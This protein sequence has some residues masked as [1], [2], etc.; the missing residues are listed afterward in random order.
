MLRADNDTRWN[1][2]HDMIESALQQEDR[3]KMFTSSVDKLADDK[4]TDL[5]W[6]ELREV[7]KLLSP[8]QQWTQFAQGKD[9]PQGSLSTVLPG[10]DM[11]LSH[12]EK[13]KK[14]S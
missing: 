8:F 2:T 13:A 6:R 1:S 9:S 10:M 5:E 14:E 3:I 12:L 11:L 7:K 4:L